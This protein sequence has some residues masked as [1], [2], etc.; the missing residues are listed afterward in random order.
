AVLRMP[1]PPTTTKDSVLGIQV[2]SMSSSHVFV[3]RLSNESGL[4]YGQCTGYPGEFYPFSC[5]CRE[6]VE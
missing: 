5:V 3:G 4:N 1:P 2:S 6:I